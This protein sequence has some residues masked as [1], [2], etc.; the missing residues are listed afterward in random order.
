MLFHP[1]TSSL[2]DFPSQSV[3]NHLNLIPSTEILKPPSLKEL[4]LSISFN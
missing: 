4:L 2:K 3:L 1:L